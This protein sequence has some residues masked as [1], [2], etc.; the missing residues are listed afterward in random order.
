MATQGYPGEFPGGL[1]E[2]FL[3]IGAVQKQKVS[4]TAGYPGLFPGGLTTGYL[5]I[6]AV[7]KAEAS[8]GGT[9]VKWQSMS[10]WSWPIG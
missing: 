4:A 1:T 3:N 6:G 2:G 10:Q 8:A 9:A 7:Q 5:G